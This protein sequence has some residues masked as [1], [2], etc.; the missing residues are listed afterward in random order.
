[1]KRTMIQKAGA[2]LLALC[3]MGTLLPTA[4]LA[5]EPIQPPQVEQPQTEQLQPAEP[6]A[7]AAQT[8]YNVA[9]A[10]EFAAAVAAIK[11]D[12]ESGTE[13]TIVLT[14]DN[15]DVAQFAGIEGKHITLKSSEGQQYT[16]VNM[17]TSLT[18][19]L[20]LDNVTAY[21]N[22]STI[23]ANGHLFET[24]GKFGDTVAKIYGGG[25]GEVTGGTNLILRGGVFTYVYGGGND[26]AVIG[27]THILVD[28]AHAMRLVGGGY[29]AAENKGTV[30]GSTYTNIRSGKIGGS[31]RG[32]YAIYGGGYNNST[33]NPETVAAVTGSTHLTFGGD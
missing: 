28:G 8:V 10:A 29:G 19:D 3:L 27:D 22:T 14:A 9:T 4:A 15:I 17:G 5:E 6:Q 24:T 32:T 21:T 12:T 18:G 33:Q 30:D 11:A 25:T 31:G 26:A 13:F 1:M 7:F 20:T 16:I 23:Y 2:A